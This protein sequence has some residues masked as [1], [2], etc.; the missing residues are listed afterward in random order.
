MINCHLIGD[1]VHYRGERVAILV[2]SGVVPSTMA[3]FT[4]ELQEGLLNED[5][6]PDP[7]DCFHEPGCPN[8]RAEI[9]NPYDKGMDDLIL[10]MKPFTRG[11][12]IRL[13]DLKRIAEQLKEEVGK[14]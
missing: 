14:E 12:L 13:D 6:R 10:N 3:D 5:E 8:H 9:T 2:A 7:C 1:E 11:G 4:D